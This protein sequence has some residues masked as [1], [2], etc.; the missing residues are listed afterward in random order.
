MQQQPATID[1]RYEQV[2]LVS[3]LEVPADKSSA[4]FHQLAHILRLFNKF[5]LASVAE[6]TLRADLNRINDFLNGHPLVS[7]VQSALS[8]AAQIAPNHEFILPTIVVLYAGGVTNARTFDEYIPNSFAINL[9]NLINRFNAKL[10]EL[11][12]KIES[13]ITHETVHLFVKQIL[14]EPDRTLGLY[15]IM[16]EEGLTTYM[17]T[18][19]M[20]WHEDMKSLVVELL[21]EVLVI[22]SDSALQIKLQS[23]VKMLKHPLYT[24]HF[25]KISETILGELAD[26]NE[27]NWKQYVLKALVLSNGPLY[28]LGYLLWEYQLATSGKSLPELVAGGHI[29]SK[30]WLEAYVEGKGSHL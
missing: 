1:A 24:K 6:E 7:V 9:G 17:E 22:L 19:H 25:A 13:L 12:A 27:A 8:R 2:N 3:L 16:W 29:Q 14:P 30:K 28:H 5:E 21:P 18:V 26:I 11:P 4:E 20:P 15:N 10:E 23:L